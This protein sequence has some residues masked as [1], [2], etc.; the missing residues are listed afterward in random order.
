LQLTG[1]HGSVEAAPVTSLQR[2]G[3]HQIEGFPNRLLRGIA[4]DAYAPAIPAANDS[5]SIGDEGLVAVLVLELVGHRATAF[6]W[7][8][9][10]QPVLLRVTSRGAGKGSAAAPVRGA[11]LAEGGGA[12][13]RV[14]GGEHR[15]D[16][17]ALLRP[18]GL[19]VPG[20]LAAQDRLRCRGS[21]RSVGRDLSGELEGDVERLARLGEAIHEPELG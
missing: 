10:L 17:L 5:V 12:L 1:G 20:S 7:P 16:D 8:R 15:G 6:E 11:L 18:E 19:L 2:R 13:D 9:S 21:E 14:L 3:Y 4:E